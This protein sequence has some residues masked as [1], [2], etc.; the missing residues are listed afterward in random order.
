[1]TNVHITIRAD[2]DK[3]HGQIVRTGKSITW[4]KDTITLIVVIST[5]KF[6]IFIQ[7]TLHFHNTIFATNRRYDLD[8]HTF[9]DESV[10]YQMFLHSY[11]SPFIMLY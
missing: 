2:L 1:M 8:G 9:K 4:T 6:I 11:S 7:I 5:T 3:T 10:S